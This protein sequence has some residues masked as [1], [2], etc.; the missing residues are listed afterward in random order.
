[1]IVIFHAFYGWRDNYGYPSFLTD[2][3]GQLS[4]FGKI[5]ENGIHNLSLNVDVFFLVS[6]FV[7]THILL[8]DKEQNGIINFKKYFISRAFRILPLYYVVLAIT[9][10]YNYFY[11]EPDPNYANFFLMIG[12]FELIERG[13]GAATVNPMWTLCIEA[14]FYFLW[15]FVI[16]FVPGKHLVKVFLSVILASV[17]FR[18]WMLHRDNW[19]MTVYMHTLSRF[20]V[21]AIGSLIALWYHNNKALSINIPRSIRLAVY[22]LFIFVFFIDDIGYWDGL[23]LITA[24][25]YFY[26]GVIAFAFINYLFNPDTMFAFKKPHPLH[27]LGKI[28]YG[29]Y[30]FNILVVA[31]VVKTYNAYGFHN[32]FLFYFVIII[33]ALAVAMVSYRFVEKPFL[34]FG[35]KLSGKN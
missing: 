11:H 29:L 33:C 32:L 3:A 25:K 20:D 2:G 12:N 13:W 15:P 18:S 1:M 5:I 17:L 27:Q 34:D 4:T 24:K 21:I 23:F 22:A 19:W 31:L 14:Q 9:P 28:T 35:K 8:S 7:I 10:L 16:R 26:V 6:G 30:V